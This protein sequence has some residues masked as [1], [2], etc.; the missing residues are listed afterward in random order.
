MDIKEKMKK[1]FLEYIYFTNS[2][3]EGSISV[4]ARRSDRKVVAAK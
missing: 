2:F 4:E 3:S 1:I